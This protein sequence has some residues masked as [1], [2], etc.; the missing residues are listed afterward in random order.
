MRMRTH[1]GSSVAVRVREH[2]APCVD[3]AT[4]ANDKLKRAT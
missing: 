2:A 4:P 3:M 1:V